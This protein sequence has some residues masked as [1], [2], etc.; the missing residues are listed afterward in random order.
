MSM[1]SGNEIPIEER[2]EE[3]VAQIKGIRIAPVDVKI[4]NPAFDVTP[5]RLLSGYVT[6]NGVLKSADIAYL[7]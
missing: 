4:L 3:E 1:E 5:S 2:P 7:S 6:E